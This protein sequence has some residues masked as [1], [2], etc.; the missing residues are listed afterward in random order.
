MSERLGTA[1]IVLT[2]VFLSAC[3]SSITTRGACN[4]HARIYC[5][6]VTDKDG[7]VLWQECRK[8]PRF[9]QATIDTLEPPLN[10]QLAA[11]KQWI[12]DHCPSE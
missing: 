12:F 1:A 11:D 8:R 10:F 2:A 4:V 3:A 9:S 7:V 6:D 5:E